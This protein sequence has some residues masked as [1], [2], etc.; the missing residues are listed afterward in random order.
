[1]VVPVRVAGNGKF[2]N[3]YALLDTGSQRNIISQDI[4]NE[5]GLDG[6]IFDMRVTTLENVSEEERKVADVV[7]KGLNGYS[8]EMKDV[9]YSCI[10]TGRGYSHG[11]GRGGLGLLPKCV[12]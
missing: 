9:V 11:E 7:L 12:L 8:T 4:G 1:M 5:L 6:D 2:V 3:T 10:Q